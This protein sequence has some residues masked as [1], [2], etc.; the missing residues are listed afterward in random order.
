MLSDDDKLEIE[1]ISSSC[2]VPEFGS[3]YLL[4]VGLFISKLHVMGYEIV[5]KEPTNAKG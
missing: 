4:D 3:G 5:K 1:T 2:I